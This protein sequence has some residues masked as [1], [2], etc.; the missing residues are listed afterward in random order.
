[1]K[2][3]VVLFQPVLRKHILSFGRYLRN[4]EFVI[5]KPMGGNFYKNLPATYEKEI[6]RVKN[7]R[8]NT[9]RRIIGIPNARFKFDSEADLFFTY[10]CFL[11]TNKPYCV[12]IE[13]GL[14]IYN[15][16]HNI[17]KNPL[18]RLIISFLLKRKNCK[19]IIFMSEAGMKSFYSTVKYS[20]RTQAIAHQKSI[21][22]YPLIEDK[23]ATPKQYHGSIKLLFVGIFYMKGGNE[24]VHAFSRIREHYQN[25]ELSIVTPLKTVSDKDITTM[26][27][28]PGLTLIDATLTETE[29]NE[30]YQKHDIFML[31]TFRDGF[32]LVLVEAISYGM[33]IICND[34]YATTEVALHGYNALVYPNHP[35][36]DYDPNTFQLFGKYYHPKNFYSALFRH[37]KERRLQPVEDF[38][39]EAIE[40]F[41]LEPTLLEKYSRNA[42]D[43][44]NKKFHQKLITERLETVFEEAL[45]R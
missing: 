4:F 15:Y 35:F 14:A 26:R 34:Q 44:Y 27:S 13:N 11:L 41:I 18:A 37:Q 39:Y 43:L 40:Q 32:G 17:A 30:L 31:P 24:L 12:Y 36:K 29:V 8:V 7:N 20:P 3:R 25:C 19:K 1:M 21:Q 33:P 22:I 10:G 38:L 16:D 6:A 23:H 2:H 45:K 9:L 5:K 28:V 42:I